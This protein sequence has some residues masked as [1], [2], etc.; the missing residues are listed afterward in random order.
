MAGEGCFCRATS[1]S[2][3]RA[4]RHRR[5]CLERRQSTRC[6]TRRVR[7]RKRKSSG[8]SPRKSS[9]SGKSSSTASRRA[10]TTPNLPLPRRRQRRALARAKPCRAPN[11]RRK[12]P[13]SSSSGKRNPGEGGREIRLLSKLRRSS[14]RNC[15]RRICRIPP[16][17][18]GSNFATEDSRQPARIGTNPNA[19]GDQRATGGNMLACL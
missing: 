18:G 12:G 8:T 2:T 4:S 15:L 3:S 1:S 7:S 9:P 6:P 17:I 14:G 11:P 5:H 16:S 10:T 19:E 13:R